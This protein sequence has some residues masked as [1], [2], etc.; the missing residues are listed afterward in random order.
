MYY[1]IF[2]PYIMGEASKSVAPSPIWTIVLNPFS[3]LRRRITSA[4]PPLFDVGGISSCSA[5]ERIK[6]W[7]PPETRNT[8]FLC[9][10]NVFIKFL[11]G[12]CTCINS[13]ICDKLGFIIPNLT[14]R[15]CWNK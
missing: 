15:D 3:S 8:S 6:Q 11:C 5:T 1:M 10:C 7:N 9:E 12:G 13:L 14:E 4:L 2:L